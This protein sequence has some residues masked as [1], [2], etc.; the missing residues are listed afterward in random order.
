MRL[1]QLLLVQARLRMARHCFRLS[2]GFA[3]LGQRLHRL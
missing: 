2:M 3:E 1:I